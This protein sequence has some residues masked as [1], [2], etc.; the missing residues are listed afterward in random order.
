MTR[1]V[2][3]G[4]LELGR[5]VFVIIIL[6]ALAYQFHGPYPTTEGRLGRAPVPSIEEAPQQFVCGETPLVVRA[7]VPTSR[8]DFVVKTPFLG[9]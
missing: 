2:T 7:N 6:T 9:V 8:I 1:L 5:T 3:I 4:L